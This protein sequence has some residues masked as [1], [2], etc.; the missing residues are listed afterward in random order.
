MA[1]YGFSNAKFTP[2]VPLTLNK[3]EKTK[4][5]NYNFAYL[6]FFYKNKATPGLLSTCSTGCQ[7]CIEKLDHLFLYQLS[8]PFYSSKHVDVAHSDITTKV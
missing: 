2:T 6:F 4:L 1:A 3:V 7:E 5:E 8:L